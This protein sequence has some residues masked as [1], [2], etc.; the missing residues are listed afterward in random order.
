MSERAR[1][2]F[3]LDVP[4]SATDALH[5]LQGDLRPFAERFEPR[6]TKREQMHLTLK[7]LGEV[8]AKHVH[9]LARV[10]EECAKD[11]RSFETS[12]E[13]LAVFPDPRRARVLVVELEPDARLSELARALDAATER[14][15]VERERRPFRPHLTLARFKAPGNAAF[16]LESVSV[17][18]TSLKLSELRLYESVRGEYVPRASV[19]LARRE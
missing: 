4:R 16:L 11:Q 6:F 19:S 18:R 2:F 7:F 14:L 12:Y 5:R 15:G 13:K 3:A 10:L 1:L 8:D 9:E 17:P